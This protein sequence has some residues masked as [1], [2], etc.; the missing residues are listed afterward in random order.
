VLAACP[1]PGWLRDLLAKTERSL[2]LTAPPRRAS[3][4][5][6]D[7]DLSERELAAVL[8][9]LASDLS[10]REVGAELYISLNTVKFH[11]RN[12]FRKLAVSSRAE[13]V[14]RGGELALL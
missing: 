11:I 10:Q 13:A 2:Q 14:A 8:R 12:I 3:G 6:S 4:P 7:P 9:L 1:D 5:P